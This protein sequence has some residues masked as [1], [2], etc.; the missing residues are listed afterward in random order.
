MKLYAKFHMDIYNAFPLNERKRNV[1][2]D[3]PDAIW[4]QKLY[5][6]PPAGMDIMIHLRENFPWFLQASDET[7]NHSE[8]E[9]Y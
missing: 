9:I 4:T 1:P 7:S 8:D 3:G 6:H 2:D 5:V